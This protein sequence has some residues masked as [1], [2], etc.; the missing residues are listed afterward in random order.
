MD[1]NGIRSSVGF[2]DFSNHSPI[3]LQVENDEDKP[4]GPF[5]FNPIWLEVEEFVK[6]VK[7]EPSHYSSLVQKY[8]MFQ[9]GE[10]LE[11]VKKSTLSWDKEKNWSL[12]EQLRKMKSKISQLYEQ[13]SNGVFTSEEKVQLKA[14]EKNKTKLL[15]WEG[16]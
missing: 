14:L 5:K 4:V 7:D 13:N 9:I 2:E 3:F 11:R 6:I 1:S 15:D 10:K 8:E 16:F 12:E